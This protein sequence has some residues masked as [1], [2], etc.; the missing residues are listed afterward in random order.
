[1]IWL[2]KKDFPEIPT[3]E[4]MISPHG[5]AT[6]VRTVADQLLKVS[7]AQDKK[8][9]PDIIGTGP[10][11][12][13]KAIPGF[14]GLPIEMEDERKNGLGWL[15][16]SL[17]VIMFFVHYF[18]SSSDSNFIK[19]WALIPSDFFRYGG[20]TTISW[21]FI[22]ADWPHL[23]SNLYFFGVFADDVEIYYGKTKFLLLI[24]SC[25]IISAFCT[26]VMDLKSNIPH[27]GISGV[28]CAIM[29]N[30]GL[31]YRK[32][33]IAFFLP[34]MYSMSN[35]SYGRLF[36]WFRIS[37]I[38]VMLGYF[39]KDLSLFFFFEL[40][41]QSNVSYSGHLIGSILGFIFWMINGCPNWYY[42]SVDHHEGSLQE[43]LLL[44]YK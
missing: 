13:W 6:L 17:A 14:L 38:W 19:D 42:D 5:D 22:H 4:D 25:L 30:Y 29:V 10:D 43:R 1:L 36:G 23:L 33:K 20:V 28:I 35:G 2:D 27:V 18:F 15:T 37:A 8:N 11:A 40:S 24:L 3:R 7:I 34:Y 44:P 31:I 16:W 39:L 41:K 26:F 21:G 32:S 9:N 12:M